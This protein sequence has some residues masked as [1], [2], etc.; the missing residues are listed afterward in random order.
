M[1]LLLLLA[2]T[3]APD[4]SGRELAPAVGDHSGAG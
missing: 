2:T 4:R 3:P 1:D